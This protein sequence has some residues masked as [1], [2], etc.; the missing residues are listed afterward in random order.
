[1]QLLTPNILKSFVSGV[2][3]VTNISCGFEH[4]VALTASGSIVSWG[5]GAS[6][7][8]G[9]GN[10][11]SYTQPKFITLG[12]LENKKVSYVEAGGYH[13]GAITEDGE[14][15]M[16]GRGDIGQLGVEQ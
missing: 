8:L 7:S 3:P 14:L 9:H 11:V 4:C 16:W 12:G 2:S 6:G 1:M 13:S 10:F 5:Y 15:Y